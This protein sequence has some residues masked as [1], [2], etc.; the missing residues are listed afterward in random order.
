[1]RF[2]I[3]IPTI[4]RLDLLQDSLPK[5][6]VD[7]KDVEIHIIDNGKQ[8]IHQNL[9]I[10]REY[11][12]VF[13]YQEDYNLGVAGSWNKL[14]NII[15]EKYENALL[16]NDDVYLGYS[17]EVVEKSIDKTKVGIVQ[18][19][20]NWSV[21]LINRDLYEF[22]GDFDE[23]FYPAYFED[24]DYIYRVKLKGLLHEID[25]TLSPKTKRS[26]GSTEMDK[27]LNKN[28]QRNRA[29]Y[30]KKWGNSPLLET[31]IKPFNKWK[32]Y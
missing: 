7:F 5:Y 11:S 21:L 32:E 13:V 20:F 28:F 2:A 3:G 29:R 22:I 27:D 1:M 6:L 31:F 24:S 25:Y 14:C 30:I 17:T 10:L 16:I 8:N 15:F 26:F 9:P 12:N 18:S 23:D 19:D 4:N